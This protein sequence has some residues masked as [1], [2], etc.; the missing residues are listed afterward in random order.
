MVP[1]RVMQAANERGAIEDPREARQMFADAD[2]GNG[3][4]DGAVLAANLGRRVR[5]GVERV[6]V[7]RAAVEEDEDAGADRSRDRWR[8]GAD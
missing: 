7:A 5:L 2:A 4:A 1:H 3:R 6:E 8:F